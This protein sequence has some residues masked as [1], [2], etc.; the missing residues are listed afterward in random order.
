M[1]DGNLQ[2]IT[3]EIVAISQ[4]A[5]FVFGKLSDAQLNWRPADEQWSVGQCFEHMIKTNELFYNE[6]DKLADG[7]RRHSLWE[8]ISPF[9]GF[10]GKMLV[11]SL[12]KDE[13]KFKAPSPKIVPP[14]EIDP[15]IV[16]IFAAH[17]SE[18]LEKIKSVEATGWEKTKVTSPFS[19]L[20]TYRLEDA[21]HVVIE[22][23]RRHFRQ[24]ERVF[25]HENFPK[26]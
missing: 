5:E 13:R 23:E 3:D 17:Q 9:S 15:N 21:F 12:K 1:A 14:S 6:L 25:K 20:L 7:T 26:N 24:A 10:F 8:R 2:N 11:K 19:R 22:H 18:L 4:N 16:E